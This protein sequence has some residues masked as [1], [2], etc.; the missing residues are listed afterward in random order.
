MNYKWDKKYLYWGVTA[1]CVIAGSMLFY[2]FL[3]DISGVL[4]TASRG[5]RLFTPVI[6]GFVFAYILAPVMNYFEKKWFRALFFKLDKKRVAKNA[7]KSV[8]KTAEQAAKSNLR[9]IKISRVL[10]VLM[11]VIAAGAVLIGIVSAVLPEVLSSIT[12]LINNTPIYI[13]RIQSWDLGFLELLPEDWQAAVYDFVQNLPAKTT[14]WLETEVMPQMTNIVGSVTSGIWNTISA[15]MNI[16]LGLIISVYLLYDKE[17][18][19]AQSKKTLYGLLKANTANLVINNARDIHRKFGGF[20]TGKLLDSAIIGALAFVIFTIFDMPFTVLISVIVGVSNVVPFFGPFIGAAVCAPL[21]LIE[22]PM[23]CVYFLIIAFILQQFDGNWLGPKILG[24]STGL[25][26]FWVIFAIVVGGRMFGFIGLLIGIPIF[27]FVYAIFKTRVSNALAK[28]EL[29]TDSNFYRD[30]SHLNVD[31][32]E[33]VKID[34]TKK[35]RVKKGK[36][37]GVFGRVFSKKK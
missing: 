32:G 34:E 11:T 24:D 19:A 27:S 37:K 16:L 35:G 28:K 25:S 8:T 6:Y 17:L 9:I 5:L 31:T 36:K 23:K 14:Q 29:P 15:L 7:A 13:A 22:D 26:S 1:F 3:T 30:V 33:F 21:I 10:G 12:T 20:I 2:T 18:F 4:R